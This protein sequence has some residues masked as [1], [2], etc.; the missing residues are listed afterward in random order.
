ML[1][2]STEKIGQSFDT[3]LKI[4]NRST[5]IAQNTNYYC[6]KEPMYTDSEYT[7][8]LHTRTSDDSEIEP[9]YLLAIFG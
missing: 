8:F 9:D 6:F 2:S 1:R 3:D 4:I 5:S 7:L